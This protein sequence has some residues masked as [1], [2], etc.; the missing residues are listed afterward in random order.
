MINAILK[1]LGGAFGT[2]A[3]LVGIVFF[4]V[5]LGLLFLGLMTAIFGEFHGRFPALIELPLA[6]VFL[7]LGYGAFRLGWKTLRS[8]QRR[9]DSLT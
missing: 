7:F 5:G 4:T 8:T 6:A 1:L 9:P 3:I 2:S